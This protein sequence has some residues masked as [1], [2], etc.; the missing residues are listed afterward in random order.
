MN[1][2]RNDPWSSSGNQPGPYLNIVAEWCKVEL[3]IGAKTQEM[4]AVWHRGQP[5]NNP[6][7]M[8]R[9]AHLM[10]IAS[11]CISSLEPL[12]V[13]VWSVAKTRA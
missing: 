9:D 4:V 10:S 3:V 7:R 13:E 8:G 2:Q 5:R 1:S 12:E 11:F 6:Q